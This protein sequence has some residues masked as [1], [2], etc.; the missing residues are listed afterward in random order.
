MYLRPLQN[1]SYGNKFG[2]SVMN[3]KALNGNVQVPW[4]YKGLLFI[5]RSIY[6]Y[7]I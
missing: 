3:K 6:F 2:Q 1:S 4:L 7:T 5:Q